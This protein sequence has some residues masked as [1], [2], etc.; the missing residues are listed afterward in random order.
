MGY[1]DIYN[2]NRN[3]LETA[4]WW[5]NDTTKEWNELVKQNIP[6]AVFK[7]EQVSSTAKN[8]VVLSGVFEHSDIN[9]TI[10]TSY[11]LN[12]I[13]KNDLIKWRDKWWKVINTQEVPV[14]NTLQ[15]SRNYS[16]DLYI[17]IKGI[18]E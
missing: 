15:L 18:E 6:N 3:A 13:K 7:V 11:R 16:Y 12:G 17:N 10:K 9:T 5:K 1:F 14:T 2:V 4:K 8:E